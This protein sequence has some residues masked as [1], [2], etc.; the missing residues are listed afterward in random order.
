MLFKSM[1][2]PEWRGNYSGIFGDMDDLVLKMNHVSTIGPKSIVQ[3]PVPGLSKQDI[4]IS[5]K[6]DRLTISYRPEKDTKYT[7]SFEFTYT[8]SKEV[9]LD[10]ISAT[11]ENGLLEV[12]FTQ[13]QS[14]VPKERIIEIT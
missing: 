3:Y 4:K 12:K 6:D 13:L 10:K 11:V 5:V 14:T 8:L 1:F 2:E 9:D 7:K